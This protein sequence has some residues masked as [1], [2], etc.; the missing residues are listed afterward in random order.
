MLLGHSRRDPRQL[1]AAGV[2]VVVVGAGC[3]PD[4]A[5]LA[6]VPSTTST[7]ASSR[8][9][10]ADEPCENGRADE[11]GAPT[12]ADDIYVDDEVLE[13]PLAT[14]GE[15]G[16][17]ATALESV[18]ARRGAEFDRAELAGGPPGGTRRRGVLQRRRRDACPQHLLHHQAPDRA[19][20]RGCG[21]TTG[22][23]LGSTRAWASGSTRSPG[24]PRLG[25]RSSSC[26]R[27]GADWRP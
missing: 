4:P 21:R 17:D 15:E 2:L 8:L 9:R 1:L 10:S 5:P 23:S 20:N 13:W 11:R 25:S 16:F 19:G 22:S 12:P 6:G 18:V 3:S 27:C 24:G 14:P 26:C 7:E